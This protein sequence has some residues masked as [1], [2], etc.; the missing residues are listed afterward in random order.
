MP[1]RSQRM[2]EGSAAV[3]LRHVIL[4][5]VD[6]GAC[7]IFYR[8][9]LGFEV[10]G[11]VGKGAERS[12]TLGPAGQPGP[13]LVLRSAGAAVGVADGGRITLAAADLDAVFERL[14]ESAAEVLQEPM[15]R[16]SGVRDCAFLDPAGTVVRIEEALGPR[17]GARPR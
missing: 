9:A 5:L 10:R 1:E 11:D 3:V 8:D 17:R 4:P 16:R 13:S 12:I 2:P 6:P 14:V 15:R 7:L